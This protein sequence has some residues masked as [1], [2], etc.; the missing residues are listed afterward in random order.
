M[1]AVIILL[2]GMVKVLYKYLVVEIKEIRKTHIKKIQLIR[3]EL[4]IYIL[5]ALDFLIAKD[6][7]HTV[8]DL[9]Y[10]RLIELSVLIVLRT[11]IG[12]FIGKE[13]EVLEKEEYIMK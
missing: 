4:G 8:T 2:I 10:E 12:F 13:V 5:L 3:C 7:I 6:I 1:I 9:S 11:I